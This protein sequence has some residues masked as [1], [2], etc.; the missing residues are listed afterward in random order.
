MKIKPQQRSPGTFSRAAAQV[1]SVARL[2]L[3]RLRGRAWAILQTSVAAELAWFITHDVLGHSQPFFAPIAAVV[4]L[5]AS[6]VLRPSPR[7]LP[8]TTATLP[9]TPFIRILRFVSAAIPI[10][11]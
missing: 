6:A 11:H 4:C 9:A 1:G 5:S 10:D 8:V 3:R 7:P 2:A